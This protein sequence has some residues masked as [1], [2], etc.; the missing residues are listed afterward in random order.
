[1]VKDGD[2][3]KDG[4]YVPNNVF[5]IGTMND[6]DRS[7]ESMD[8]AIRRRFTWKEVTADESAEN[9]GIS[10]LAL[11][12]MKALNKALLECDLTEA[13]CIGGAYFLKV[14]D[15][16]FKALWDLR[17]KGVISEY[18]RGDPESSRKLKKVEEKYFAAGL[19]APVDTQ[20]QAVADSV[21]STE[22]E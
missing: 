11:A 6:V 8:F 4:F 13:Y 19:A 7:V 1:M 9:M 15:D 2:I 3:F 10:G 20:A 18:F 22:G 17:L 16:D 14:T 21:S 12:K 5:I